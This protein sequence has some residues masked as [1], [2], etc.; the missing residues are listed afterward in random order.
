[1]S[2]ESRHRRTRE[3]AVA[4][5]WLYK[6]VSTASESLDWSERYECSNRGNVARGVLCW[7]FAKAIQGDPVGALAK[8]V[9]ACH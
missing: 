5:Q 1:M 4:R 3:D 8:Q 2:A 9:S 7:V 6:H